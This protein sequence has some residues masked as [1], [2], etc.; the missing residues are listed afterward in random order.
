MEFS[1]GC[2]VFSGFA[3]CLTVG[4]VAYKSEAQLVTRF[5]TSG[6]AFALICASM[7]EASRWAKGRYRSKEEPPSARQGPAA[8]VPVMEPGVL[9]NNA[10]FPAGTVL[11]GIRWSNRFTELRI[12]FN[13][14][15]SADYRDLDFRLAPDEPIAAATQITNLPDV[16]FSAAAKLSIR[17]EFVQGATSKRIANP[18]VLIATSGGYR[19]RCKL[20]P[21]ASQLEILLAVARVVD[22]PK[23]GQK[24][25]TP[26]SGIFDR[27]Y[28]VRI[29]QSDGTSHWY[30]HGVDAHGNRI[31][32]VYKPQRVVPKTVKIEGRYT[33]GEEEKTI[34]KQLQAKDF[35]ADF[36]KSGVVKP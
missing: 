25:A 8:P 7:V 13:N 5:L 19:M 12:I 30:G 6:L 32:D 21:R 28:A 10:E 34:S 31:E 36:L 16:S 33:V 23:P 18:L 27:S 3:L 15:S 26:D 35:I 29:N 22:F 1:I 11:G 2:F 14:N 17:Q 9:V 20:L 4:I 24:I